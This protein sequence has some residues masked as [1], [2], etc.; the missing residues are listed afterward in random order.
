MYGSSRLMYGK[1]IINESIESNIVNRHTWL[2][3]TMSLNELVV[4]KFPTNKW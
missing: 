1:R 4:V 3:Y 2:G